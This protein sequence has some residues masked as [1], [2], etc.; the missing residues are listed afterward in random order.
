MAGL[1]HDTL[2]AVVVR[3]VLGTT[4]FPH[5]DEITPP[6]VYQRAIQKKPSATGSETTLGQS[7]T[8]TFG[9]TTTLGQI[10]TLSPIEGGDDPMNLRSR[11][12]GVPN[13]QEAPAPTDSGPLPSTI[14]LVTPEEFVK[15]EKEEGVDSL[16]VTWYG[17]ND[18]EVCRGGHP[19][20][21]PH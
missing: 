7:T 21:T 10:T 4:Y 15:S 11:D 3:S 12:L 17:P 8:S 16:L 6:S 19:L 2:F 13:E 20:R 18:P 9:Q 14:T 1:F 5:I